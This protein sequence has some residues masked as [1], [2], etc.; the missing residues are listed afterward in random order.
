MDRLARDLRGLVAH[1]VGP[2]DLG[3]AI[4]ETLRSCVAFDAVRLVATNPAAELGLGSFSCWHRY[5]SGLLSALVLDRYLGGDPCRPE[6]LNRLSVP[7]AVVGVDGEHGARGRRTARLL[8]DNGA[9]GELRALLR[10]RR[11]VWGF[12]GL[13]R[14]EDARPFDRADLNRVAEL[15]PAC[16][17]AIREFARGRP[18]PIAPVPIAPGIITVGSDHAVKGISDEAHYWLEQLWTPGRSGAAEWVVA[19]FAP[20]VYCRARELMRQGIAPKPLICASAAGSGRWIAIHGRALAGDDGEVAIVIQAARGDLLLPSFCHWH[21]LTARQRA[22][23]EQL[24]TGDPPR[25][26]AKT[27]AVSTHTVNAHLKAVYHKT[28]A[29]GR[30]ELMAALAC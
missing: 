18:L 17:A 1:A 25:T 2:D 9:S 10:D 19:P 11:G 26:I 29:D 12:L 28:G 22:I 21:E 30:D 8:S 16:N 13:L 24:C 14:A 7:A 27:L 6:D 4:A 20:E 5:D 23:L 15:G 3:A